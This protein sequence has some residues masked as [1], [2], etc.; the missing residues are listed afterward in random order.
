MPV[1]ITDTCNCMN[2]AH[3]D[4]HYWMSATMHIIKCRNKSGDIETSA[5]H[6]LD[7]H[8]QWCPRWTPKGAMK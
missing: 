3:L 8:K 7:T 1:K 2:C 5:Y 4:D 6:A